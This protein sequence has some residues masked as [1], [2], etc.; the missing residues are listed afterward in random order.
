MGYSHYWY[1]PEKLDPERFALWTDHVRE[2]IKSSEANGIRIAGGDGTGEP[3]ITD[4]EVWFNGSVNQDIGVWTTNEDVVIPWFSDSANTQP[5]V[6]DPSVDK[7]DGV[8]Y[9]GT[10]VSQRVAPVRN[11]IGSGDY[12][13]FCVNVEQEQS[14]WNKGEPLV[15]SCVK[16]A[17]RP[18]DLTVNAA[19]VSF[20]HF[21]GDSV[22]VTSDGEPKDWIDGMVMCHNLFGYGMDFKLDG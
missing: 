6:A 10:L 22:R 9:A 11:G 19:L 13:T 3:S 1:R 12:E 7:T 14:E 8:W 20:K 16:T 18:Y 4:T 15:F 21:F 5:E 2:I 17:C